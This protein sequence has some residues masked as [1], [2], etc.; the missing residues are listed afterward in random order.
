[1]VGHFETVQ[2]IARRDLLLRGPAQVAAPI[3]I[4]HRFVERLVR[5]GEQCA[6]AHEKPVEIGFKHEARVV[7]GDAS[8]LFA[9]SVQLAKRRDNLFVGAVAQHFAECVGDLTTL[10]LF[11]EFERRAQ[12]A[13]RDKRCESRFRASFSGLFFHVRHS[14]PFCME[15]KNGGVR[16]IVARGPRARYPFRS[17][18]RAGSG[19]GGR[20]LPAVSD[21]S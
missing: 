20:P 7:G 2:C 1:M 15:S 8:G 6:G 13:P 9:E 16:P 12:K 17:H 4:L 11:G 18:R 10:H 5:H 19:M 21:A 14:G 3:F